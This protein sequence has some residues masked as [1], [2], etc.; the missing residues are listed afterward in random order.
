MI[1]VADIQGI[2]H[3]PQV[4]IYKSPLFDLSLLIDTRL[5]CLELAKHS[6]LQSMILCTSSTVLHVAMTVPGWPCLKYVF[7][8][9]VFT[10]V[11]FAY[12]IL[13]IALW[14]EF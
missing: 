8:S 9:A 1:A 6:A 14:Q 3:C 2:N 11:Y 12:Y 4:S 13:C 10:C 7:L 5:Y